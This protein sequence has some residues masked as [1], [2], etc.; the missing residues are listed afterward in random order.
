MTFCQI[1]IHN[2]LCQIQNYQAHKRHRWPNDQKPEDKMA[3][4]DL[5][6]GLNTASDKDSKTSVP[7]IRKIKEMTKFLTR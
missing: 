2:V 7:L 6:D 1:I 3:E 4:M 5:L